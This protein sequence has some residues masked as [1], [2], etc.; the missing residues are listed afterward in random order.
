MNVQVDLYL[1][2][3]HVVIR[4]LRYQINAKSV[5]LKQMFA[6]SKI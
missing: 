2:C 3:S 6:K 5:S 1:Y 4:L